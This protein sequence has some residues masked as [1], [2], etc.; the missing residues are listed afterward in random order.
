MNRPNPFATTNFFKP[1][2]YYLSVSRSPSP[3]RG[4]SRPDE[5]SD[6]EMD[7]LG[8]PMLDGG[9]SRASQ[10]SQSSTSELK[11]KLT[12][13]VSV[14][15][16][17]SPYARA[18]VRSAAHSEDDEEEYEMTDAAQNRPLV[19]S[20]VGKGSSNSSKTQRFFQDGGLGHFFFATAAGWHVYFA[21]IVFWVGGCQFGLL[22]MNR[23]ILWTG[24]YKYDLYA[25]HLAKHSADPRPDSPIR[26][27]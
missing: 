14:S 19:V 8:V 20:H 21:L 7:R 10:Y 26:S 3:S 9:L 5:E 18:G 17:P 22:L 13:L 4:R 23:F 16:S 27:P 1:A 11:P 2:S 6:L 24:T 25:L 12:S 15:R